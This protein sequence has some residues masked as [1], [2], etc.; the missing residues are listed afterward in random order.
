MKPQSASAGHHVHAFTS[1]GIFA[2][3]GIKLGNAEGTRMRKPTHTGMQARR[4]GTKML[5]IAPNKS[6]FAVV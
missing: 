4:Y 3:G 1:T 2:K 6:H 5:N